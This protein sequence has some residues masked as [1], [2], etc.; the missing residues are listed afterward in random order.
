MA[1]LTSLDLQTN[2]IGAAGAD[3]LGWN[4][5]AART[6]CFSSAGHSES[7]TQVPGSAE[8]PAE[9][10]CIVQARGSLSASPKQAAHPPGS[11]PGAS[12]LRRGS[13]GWHRGLVG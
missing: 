9:G 12:W 2:T 3:A 7:P 13:S 4:R 8:G 1:Q 6:G 5:P 11:G 10:T